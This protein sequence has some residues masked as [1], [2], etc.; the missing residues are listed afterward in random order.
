M[1]GIQTFLAANSASIG[2]V[3][4]GLMFLGFVTERLPAA[5]VAVLGACAFLLL[6]YLGEEA[7]MRALANPAPY[8]IGAMFILSGAL[9]RT[10]TIDAIANKIVERAGKHP[11]LALAELFLGAFVASAFMNNTPV[12]MVLIPIMARMAHAIG[13]TAKRLLMPLSF[14]AILG[15]TTTLIGTSTN[16]IVDAVARNEGLRPFGI[17]E[18]TPYGLVAAATGG[19][20]MLVMSRWLLPEGDPDTL[21]RSEDDTPFLTQLTVCPDSG[22]IGRQLGS[23]SSLRRPRTEI[24]SL[25]RGGRIITDDVL[26][27]ALEPGDRI[28]VRTDV[29]ELLSLRNSKLFEVGIG[30]VNAPPPKSEALVEATISPSHP[31]LGRHLSDIPFLTRLRVRILGIARHGHLPGPDLPKAR[32]R[33]ADRVLVTGTSDAVRRMYENPGL[34]GV[35]Q[36]RSRAFRRDRAPI[37]IISLAAVVILAAL[38]ILPIVIAAIIAVGVILAT[39]CIDAEEAW[40]SID[41]GVLILIF[42]MLAVGMALE[43]TGSAALVVQSLAPFLE[44][45]PPWALVFAVYGLC[46]LMTEIITNNAVAILVTPL[47]IALARDLGTDPRPLVIAV[48]FAASASF[49]TPIG[50]QTNTL[51]YAAG[52][53]RFVDF[54]KFGVPVTLFVAPMTCLAILAFY[55]L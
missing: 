3:I 43:H 47:V 36:T 50:Y 54:I 20:V 52:D 23:F 1:G 27:Y 42:A 53:Y 55:T 48:M 18:I 19:L 49:A 46:V 2:L 32:I 37:A 17:F 51:V 34:L 5:V 8:T 28:A 41:G 16:L 39:R 31:S 45:V 26:E 29:S 22:A 30:G 13:T 25:N 33:A 11:R 7:L 14:I 15:G 35:G 4:L 38:D 44:R 21:Y 9:L 6:G 40:S 10:G 12:V 24:V